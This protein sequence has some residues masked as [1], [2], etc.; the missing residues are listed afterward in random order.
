MAD[1]Y[2]VVQSEPDVIRIN[3]GIRRD[4]ARVT[5]Q[6]DLTQLKRRSDY[7]CKLAA[8]PVWRQRFGDQTAEAIYQ[9]ALAENK[10]TTETANQ[11]ARER[12]WRTT[13]WPWQPVSLDIGGSERPG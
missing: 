2:G 11:V 10:K 6:W 1:V 12:G 13:Y 5:D 3:E 7:I 8:Q 9:R 4:M